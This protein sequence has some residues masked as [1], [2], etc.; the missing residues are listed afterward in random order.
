MGGQVLTHR[1]SNTLEFSS[2]FENNPPVR[3]NFFEKEKEC[4]VL[5]Q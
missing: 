4:N 2:L 5:T 3:I 1:G